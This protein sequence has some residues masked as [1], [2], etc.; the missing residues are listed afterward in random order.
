MRFGFE[1]YPWQMA[2]SDYIGHLDHVIRIASECGIPGIETEICMLGSYADAPSLLRAD[3]DARGLHLA[4][5]CYVEDWRGAEETRDE[6]GRADWVIDYLNGFPGALLQLCPRSGKDRVD[7]AE[8]QRNAIQCMS[9]VA[10]RA[11]GKGLLCTVHPSSPPGSVF[12]TAEDYGV[13][14]TGVDPDLVGWTPD[15][16][17]IFRGGMDPLDAIKACRHLVRLVHLKDISASGEPAGYG[18]GSLDLPAVVTYLAETG[19][20]GW[21]IVD[22]ESKLAESDPDEAARRNAGYIRDRLIPLLG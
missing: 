13:L 2:S 14:L 15:T 17:N 1:A 3:L 6:A 22:D 5:I 9:D 10:R 21:V 11:A 12:R 19:Y 7:L 16:G 18:E 8:R 20:D 4:A